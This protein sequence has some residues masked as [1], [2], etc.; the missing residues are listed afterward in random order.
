M[1]GESV[2]DPAFPA[3]P[4]HKVVIAT[5]DSQDEPVSYYV[6]AGD[7]Q[8]WDKGSDT[9]AR[10]VFKRS[11]DDQETIGHFTDIL[12]DGA[13]VDSGNYSAKAGS[14]DVELT[15]AYLG[16]LA[17]GEHSITANFDDADGA[18]AS[19]TV[20]EAGAPDEGGSGDG[21]GN[22]D[23]SGESGSGEQTPKT[24]DDAQLGLLLAVTLLACAALISCVL[25]RRRA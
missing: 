6:E 16:T 19:F 4:A 17:V 25:V 1:P 7:G 11:V 22:D 10:F 18:T 14:V 12:V 20:R 21:S 8:V 5:E 24:G 3:V 9:A 15:P 23:G 2:Y 13:V